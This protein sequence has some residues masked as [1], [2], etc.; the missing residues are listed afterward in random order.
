[1]FSILDELGKM[2]NV[3]YHSEV[4]VHRL[5]LLKRHSKISLIFWLQILHFILNH[6]EMVTMVLRAGSPYMQLGHLKELAQLTG[7]I[8]RSSYHGQWYAWSLLTAVTNF[9]SLKCQ[10]VYHTPPPPPS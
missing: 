8:A 10:L 1:M 5:Q 2:E 6:S 7:V 3:V 9:P 4:T